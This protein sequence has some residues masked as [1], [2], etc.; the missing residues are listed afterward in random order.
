MR[1]SKQPAVEASSGFPARNSNQVGISLITDSPNAL[2]RP[3]VRLPRSLRKMEEK[4]Q[5]LQ[6]SF[7]K[8]VL[9]RLQASDPPNKNNRPTPA[10]IGIRPGNYGTPYLVTSRSS[11]VGASY[12]APCSVINIIH[13]KFAQAANT[14]TLSAAAC[15]CTASAQYSEQQHARFIQL[16]SPSCISRKCLSAATTSMSSSR[17]V[18]SAVSSSFA[19][20]P[21][22][23]LRL[24][25]HL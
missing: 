11:H 14:R 12:S 18:A 7:L 5:A 1:R 8:T 16:T 6:S 3:V 4:G 2:S 10:H 23:T 25:V 15:T 19:V 17:S 22:V 13:H 24:N 20:M 21:F 9:R